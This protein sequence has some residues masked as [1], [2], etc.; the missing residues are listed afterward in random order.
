MH[1]I[2]KT[3]F[4]C[5]LVLW[6]NFQLSLSYRASLSIRLQLCTIFVRSD[7]LFMVKALLQLCFALWTENN[8]SKIAECNSG[9][10][11]NRGARARTRSLHTNFLD[12][13]SPEG[14]DDVVPIWSFNAFRYFIYFH[15]ILCLHAAPFAAF[16]AFFFFLFAIFTLIPSL[17]PYSHR[18]SFAIRLIDISFMPLLLSTLCAFSLI[19]C[20]SQ[21]IWICHTIFFIIVCY[22]YAQFN[23]ISTVSTPLLL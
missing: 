8:T 16:L 7:F 2:F 11:S 10:R 3:V 9:K 15:L 21:Q 17:F 14:A 18:N 6:C 5:S 23:S 4:I 22:K 13:F 12:G 19:R 1:A 20:R